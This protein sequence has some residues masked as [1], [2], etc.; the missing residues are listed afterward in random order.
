MQVEGGREM[1]REY[2]RVMFAQM[3]L[4]LDYNEKKEYLVADND[5]FK[6]MEIIMEKVKENDVIVFPEM[7][8]HFKYDSYFINNSKDKII[9]FGSEY[10]GSEN[11]TAVYHNNKRYNIKKIFNSG[12]EPSIRYGVDI[13]VKEFFKVYLKEHTF[14]LKG[15]KFIVLNCAEYYKVAYF[16][17]RDQFKSRDV[18]AFLVPC[19]NNNSEV[20]LTESKAI[21]NHNDR[22]YSFIVNSVST[23]KG[24]RYSLGESY[25]FGRVSSF[26][27]ECLSKFRIKHSS[28]ICYLDDGCYLVE[29]MYLYKDSSVFYR[30]DN[31]RHT[32]KNIKIERM[33]F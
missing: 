18:F 13:D 1:D 22:I 17:A 24:E 29:G 9:V 14:K 33:D 28:N 4:K 11:Y 16:I 25:V 19:A 31:Y 21:H 32:P 15:Q 8:Y 23:Y 20:F 6:Q 12:V 26:E 5:Y 2:F 30:S 27:K 10:I 7:S 3:K